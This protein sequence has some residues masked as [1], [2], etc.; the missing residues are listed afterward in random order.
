MINS[1]LA[2]FSA[3]TSQDNN[4]RVQSRAGTSN[5]II[6]EWYSD[7]IYEGIKAIDG[8]AIGDC[9]PVHD[10]NEIIFC[11][12]NFDL[13]MAYRDGT[14]WTTTTLWHGSGQPLTPAIGDFD[15]DHA[16]NEI[17]LVGMHSGFEDD[18]GLGDAVEIYWNATNAN[19]EN[20]VIFNNPEMLHGAAIGDIDPRNVGD[21]LVVVGFEYRA[22]LLKK[23]NHSWVSELMWEDNNNVRKAVI[24]DFDSDHDGDEL[25]VVSKSGKCTMIYW[26][27]TQWIS[28]VLW[29]DPDGLARVA[30]GDCDQDNEGKEIVVGSDSGKVYLIRDIG[31]SWE[32]ILLFDDEDKNRGVWIG[33]V[34]PNQPGNEIIAYGYSKNV[35]EIYGS[36]NTW[37]SVTI[38]TDSARGHEVRIGEFDSTHK[39]NEILVVGYSNNATMVAYNYADFSITPLEDIQE[40]SSGG[41]AA[42]QL[43]IESIEGFDRIVSFTPISGIPLIKSYNFNPQSLQPDDTVILTINIH[44]TNI[45]EEIGLTVIGEGGGITHS[46]L[47]NLDVTG[48]IISPSVVELTEPLKI[49]D[50][51]TDT[52]I[53]INFSENM[54][55][56][57]VESEF[58]LSE[59]ST[60]DNILGNFSWINENIFE[61]RPNMNLDN[62]T[63]YVTIIGENSADLAGNKLVEG[64]SYSFST[65]NATKDDKKDDNCNAILLPVLTLVIIGALMFIGYSAK[66]DKLEEEKEMGNG[67]MD[68]KSQP[69]VEKA[70]E[71]LEPEL[72]PEPEPEPVEPTAP[73]EEVAPKPSE[74]A[75]VTPKVVKPKVKKPKVKKSKVKKSI[76]RK[77]PKIKKKPDVPPPSS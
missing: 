5:D 42:F 20:E 12:R 35:T 45:S 4:T 39:G 74:E 38:W 50:V 30:V 66:K 72:E 24:D 19:W 71:E 56:S 77:T 58:S 26:N 6:P 59:E 37:E 55:K 76:K 75:V 27:G 34:D 21:E 8:C 67:E 29:T 60:G 36:G 31:D 10:G 52:S 44:P 51:P 49:T 54:N 70:E 17:I 25:V 40:I 11:D 46:I 64:K 9:Y 65:V 73:I 41:Q 32:H 13:V 28:K 23:V 68:R 7:V 14:A 16:G 3:E 47:L 61:F 53:K 69:I 15:P 62:S 43:S 57:S 18:G 2:S 63:R 1:I 22:T 48:D 33:D